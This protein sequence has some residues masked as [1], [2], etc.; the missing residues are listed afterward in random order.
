MAKAESGG[1]GARLVAL[2]GRARRSSPFKAWPIALATVL[3]AWLSIR[4]ILEKTGG[5][6]AV[7]LDD[8]YIHFQYAR[9][10]A[11]G[12]PLVYSPGCGPVGGA[13]SL[14][15]PLLL[16]PGYAL[17]LREH[18]MVWQAWALGFLTLGLL[19]HEAQRAA[20]G[21]ASPVGAAG[22]RYATCPRP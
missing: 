5:V 19:A 2:V 11:A 13:T 7:P 22:H 20:R 6:P 18:A 10:F 14:L 4:N 3:L 17:G 15:W 16:A 8:A 1:L 9:G 12:K 21:L